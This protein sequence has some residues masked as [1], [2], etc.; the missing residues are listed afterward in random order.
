MPAQPPRRTLLRVHMLTIG[1]A[2]FGA[3]AYAVWAAV[4]FSK[5]RDTLPAVLAPIA[6]MLIQLAVSRSREYGADATGARLVGYPDGLIG[7]LRKLQA[8][9]E[10][11]PMRAA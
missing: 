1:L 5:T 2:I 4:R 9:S 6:A 10:R 8:A 11:I 7:A 3:I